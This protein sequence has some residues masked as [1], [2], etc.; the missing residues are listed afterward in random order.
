MSD[1]EYQVSEFCLQSGEKSGRERS[2]TVTA[3]NSWIPAGGRWTAD[4]K[5]TVRAKFD[6]VTSM[7]RNLPELGKKDKAKYLID[8]VREV[9]GPITVLWKTDSRGDPITLEATTGGKIRIQLV[10]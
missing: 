3:K 9:G 8:R 7:I 1:I 5:D 4:G 6:S 10:G 2:I